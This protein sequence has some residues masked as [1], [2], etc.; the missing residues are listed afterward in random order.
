MFLYYSKL[1]CLDNG[2]K[3]SLKICLMISV[4]IKLHLYPSFPK[5]IIFLIYLIRIFVNCRTFF[6]IYLGR[7]FLNHFIGVF[8]SRIP[9]TN[10]IKSS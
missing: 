2:N 9:S 8:S 1:L 10:Y 7:I 5:T 4:L 3:I 6:Y